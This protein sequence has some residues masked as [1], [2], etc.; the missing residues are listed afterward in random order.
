MFHEPTKEIVCSTPP[1]P[2]HEHKMSLFLSKKGHHNGV[3]V[4]VK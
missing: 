1:T 4:E 2:Q 3:V